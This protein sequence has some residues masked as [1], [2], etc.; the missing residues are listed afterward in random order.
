MSD[1]LDKDFVQ[2]VT[3]VP[4]PPEIVKRV[5]RAK[6]QIKQLAG[7]RNECLAM[8]RGDHYQFQPGALVNASGVLNDSTRLIGPA[9]GVEPYRAKAVRN[10][11]PD[12]VRREVSIAT[13]R[14][15]VFD[16]LPTGTD[17]EK[18]EAANVAQ[19]VALY[20]HD[21]WKFRDLATRVATL[22]VITGEGFAWPYF[23]STVGPYI[24][25]GVGV[26]EIKIRIL[27]ANQVG[28]QPG[29]AYDDSRWYVVQ[30]VLPI[31]EVKEMFG[32]MGGDLRGDA[33]TST[34]INTP[35]DEDNSLVLVT[36][37]L[38]RPSSKYQHGRR[39]TIANGRQIVK[40]RPYP[41]VDRDDNVIDE[42]VLVRLIRDVDPENDRPRGMVADLVGPQRAINDLE[43]RKLEAKNLGLLP[44]LIT[45]NL[46]PTAPAIKP[47]PGAIYNLRGDG[48]FGWSPPIPAQIIT[49]LNDMKQ[50]TLDDMGR[51]VAQN[52][53]PKNIESSKALQVYNERDVSARA[54][55]LSNV[56]EWY[57]RTMQ[58]CLMLVQRH[59]TEPRVIRING[60]N[61]SESIDNFTGAQLSDEIDV[62]V[63]PASIEPRTR[64]G[65]ANVV[66]Q[67]LQMGKVDV[68]RGL[69]AIQN[70][71]LE[72][73]TESYDK[74]VAR[75]N[76]VIQSLKE[77]PETFL[78][79]Q[80]M[81]DG[82]PDFM[83]RKFDNVSV[84]KQV[85]EDWM[86]TV[87]F[88]QSD[89]VIKEAAMLY[90][91]GLD[92]LEQQRAAEEQ[93]RQIQM[94][95]GLGMANAA[96]PGGAGVPS[97]PSA[98]PQQ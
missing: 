80:G 77:G 31:D 98:D 53:P 54:V 67:L 60:I 4:P 32:Y 23:D 33:S 8:Y 52:D 76:R 10:F 46:R 21:K 14:T 41:L 92:K 45:K 50:T 24:Q 22:A 74:D 64:E 28:W 40:E 66:N 70:G 72:K 44:M 3:Q 2:A 34:L 62:R 9:S 39:L 63:S 7:L 97:L 82:T 38:E 30:H 94:A 25:E 88:E 58:R 89:P 47:V 83:P 29:V 49:Q 93:Q 51:I 95:Q 17:R 27:H 13:T 16:V 11:I 73:L 26:G 43:S 18:I 36:E 81:P 78:A 6:K 19:K 87:D 68:Q 71:S 35:N 79:G 20:G 91:D 90:Y 56:A 85:F 69:L 42:P 59:Y 57:A 75:A 48:E 65:V 37:Y 96:K 84:H 5:E 15:P 55:F 61:G 12:F 1:K 86:K